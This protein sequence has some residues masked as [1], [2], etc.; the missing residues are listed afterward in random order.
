M[1]LTPAGGAAGGGASYVYSFINDIGR[2]SRVL[3]G[4]YCKLVGFLCKIGIILGEKVGSTL[5]RQIFVFNTVAYKAKEPTE[6]SSCRLH[7][8]GGCSD[9]K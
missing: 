9:A 3:F 7:E 4:L 5:P 8:K 1:S 2:S 6:L